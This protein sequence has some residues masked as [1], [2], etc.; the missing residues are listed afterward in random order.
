MDGNTTECTQ[1]DIE[2]IRKLVIARPGCD[3]PDFTKE[4]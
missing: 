4:P 3:V 1:E 2:E